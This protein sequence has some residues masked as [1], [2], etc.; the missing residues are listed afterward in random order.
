V[1][2]HGG[3]RLNMVVRPRCNARNGR[4]GWAKLTPHGE[5]MLGGAVSG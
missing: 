1:V 4:R 3:V 2:M 5:A